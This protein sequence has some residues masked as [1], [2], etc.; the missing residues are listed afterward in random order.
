M[1]VAEKKGV[2]EGGVF[3][4]DVKLLEKSKEGDKTSFILNKVS[5]EFA[6]L[7]RRYMIEE[8]PVMAIEDIEFNK[9][10][11]IL[12]D[13]IVAHRL[14]LVPLKTDLK[15]YNLPERCKCKGKGCARCTLKMTLNSKSQ[16]NVYA[17]DIKPK[18]PKIKPVYPKTPIVVLV[19]GQEIGLEAT[20]RL[21]K[22]KE[23]VK[24]SPC[25]A[26]YKYKPVVELTAKGEACTELVEKCP[27]KI[28]EMKN[29]KVIV[30]KNNLIKCHLCNA[31]VDICKEGVKL[32]EKDDEFVFY[33]ESFGQLSCKEIAVAA[34]DEFEE[35][36][37]EFVNNIKKL[38]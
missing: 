15:S 34:L 37:Q 18:D 27:Q 29:N 7:L 13:E 4:M 33:I 12:Y 26:Y 9:N 35:K 38:K 22:G 11:S 31:C 8:V 2:K 32:E 30:N 1:T 5:I 14:G 19:K 16:G 23:H 10:N 20:A 6:N 24:W 36:I 28:F 25:L 17:G 21:G 3:K